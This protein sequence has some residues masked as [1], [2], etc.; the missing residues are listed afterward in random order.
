MAHH[1]YVARFLL[2]RWSAKGRFVAYYC[3]KNSKKPIKNANATVA[4]ACQIPDLNVFFG[5]AKSD[6]DMPETKF[7]TPY[8]DTPAAAALRTILDDGVRA[9][10]AK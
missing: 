9:L 3:D 5:V 2:W 6:R 10:T 4:R 8:V 1:H 7:F